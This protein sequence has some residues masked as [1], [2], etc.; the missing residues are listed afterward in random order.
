MT[1]LYDASEITEVEAQ[2]IIDAFG[3]CTTLYEC[4]ETDDIME[5]FYMR[6]DFRRGVGCGHN[7]V[8]EFILMQL[9]CEEIREDRAN[10]AACHQEQSGS[11]MYPE[12]HHAKVIKENKQR[13]L[14]LADRCFHAGL[15]SAEAF[16][17]YTYD[18]A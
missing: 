10:D 7:T 12:G 1:M 3:P 9:T 5:D 16:Q 2:K 13:R 4:N 8:E 17:K 6:A 18:N 11:Y 15:L 14:D